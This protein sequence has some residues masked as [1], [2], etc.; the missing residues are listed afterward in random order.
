[1][2]DNSKVIILICQQSTG[3]CHC[4]DV[5]VSYCSDRRVPNGSNC[6]YALSKL[7]S[8]GYKIISTQTMDDCCGQIIYTLAKISKPKPL[9][10]PIPK[11]DTCDVCQKEDNDCCSIC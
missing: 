6:A 1:M 7:L 8:N 3:W 9:P 10:K 4:N 2:K 5:Y 11:P